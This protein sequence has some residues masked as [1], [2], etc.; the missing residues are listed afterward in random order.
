VRHGD[1][2]YSEDNEDGTGEECGP[3]CGAGCR[4]GFR[5]VFPDA[6]G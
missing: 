2:K 4:H 5:V 3:A 6:T 1:E